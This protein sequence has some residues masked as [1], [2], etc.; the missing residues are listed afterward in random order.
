MGLGLLVSAL[1]GRIERVLTVLP[2]LIIVEM[3]L[4]MGGI[5][6]EVASEPVLKQLSYVAGTQWGFS[7]SASTVGLNELEPLNAL[8]RV[9][10]SIDLA[11]PEAATSDL[12][13]ALRGEPRWDHTAGAWGRSMFALAGLSVV[14][15]TGSGLALHR[16]DPHR[17]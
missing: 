13:G 9:V 10:P 14:T 5:F 16:Y 3:I 15:I 8:A 17:P 11:N 4:A 2:V 12:A 6:P 7:A 1:S